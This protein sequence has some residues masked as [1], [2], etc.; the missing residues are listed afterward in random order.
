[1]WGLRAVCRDG[2]SGIRRFATK[3]YALHHLETPTGLRFVLTTDVGVADASP[4]LWHMYAVLWREHVALNPLQ[5]SGEPLSTPGFF[6]AVDAYLR[7]ESYF[8]PP[9]ASGGASTAVAASIRRL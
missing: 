7:S 9:A 5:P 1:M 8:H 3:S 6:E 4:V 2:E